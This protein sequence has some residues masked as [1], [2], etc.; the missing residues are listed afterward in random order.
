[1]PISAIDEALARIYERVVRARGRRNMFLMLAL[2]SLI[3]GIALVALQLAPLPRLGFV[4][5]TGIEATLGTYYYVLAITWGLG[6]L[7]GFLLFGWFAFA[8]QIEAVHL[9]AV[10]EI[11]RARKAQT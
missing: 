8:A 10:Y 11:E 3:A 6:G 5:T 4:A 1:M 7:A 2:L 9:A